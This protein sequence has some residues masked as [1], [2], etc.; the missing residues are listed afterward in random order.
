LLLLVGLVLK[1]KGAKM[2]TPVMESP[3]PSTPPVPPPPTS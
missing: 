1:R 3:T 2:A